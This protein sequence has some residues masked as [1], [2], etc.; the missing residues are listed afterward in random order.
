MNTKKKFYLIFFVAVSLLLFY[1][2]KSSTISFTPPSSS[3]SSKMITSLDDFKDRFSE[4]QKEKNFEAIMKELAYTRGVDNESKEA[5]LTYL[6]QSYSDEGDYRYK[7]V[8]LPKSFSFDK[9]AEEALTPKGIDMSLR[10]THAM[11][12]Y[13][14][15]KD[16]SE[17]VVLNS[18]LMGL[19]GRRVLFTLSKVFDKSPLHFDGEK[20]LKEIM[21]KE[22]AKPKV[23]V[24]SETAKSMMARDLRNMNQNT[25]NPN[26]IKEGGKAK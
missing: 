23:V 12:T 25:T 4:L 1:V 16:G 5:F 7:V 14:T 21:K 17:E 20:H 9:V 11:K 13:F 19:N 18:I 6:K 15:P 3:P 10:P 2:F 26:P 22:A 24:D 8:P